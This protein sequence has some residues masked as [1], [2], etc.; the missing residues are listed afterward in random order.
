MPHLHTTAQVFETGPIANKRPIYAGS[1]VIVVP[2][3]APAEA[4]GN[5]AV[6]V[7]A[8]SMGKPVV[9]S[10][11]LSDCIKK[12]IASVDLSGL[13]FGADEAE[14]MRLAGEIAQ[15]RDRRRETWE[16]GRRLARALVDAKV[17]TADSSG[18]TPEADELIEYSGTHRAINRAL[19]S[20]LEHGNADQLSD[21]L[22]S[23]SSEA[24]AREIIKSLIIDR[25]ASILKTEQLAFQ[26]L[27]HMAPTPSLEEFVGRYK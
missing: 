9:A 23:E 10:L 12:L 24:I 6:Y 26:N 15:D 27:S 13:P 4:A 19:H 22:R 25:Q 18:S 20:W 17:I 8:L 16:A 2:G 14:I 21:V 3:I 7:H 5:L 11:A 1:R